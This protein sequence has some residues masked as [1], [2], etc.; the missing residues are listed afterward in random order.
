MPKMRFHD[1]RHTFA[2]LMLAAGFK[3]YEVSRWMGHANVTTTDSIYAHLY[4]SDYAQ[5]V[6]KF[7]AFVSEG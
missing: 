4:P 5:Q 1:L 7:E 2:S 3:P 6:A